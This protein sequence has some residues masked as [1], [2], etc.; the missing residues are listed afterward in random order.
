[1]KGIENTTRAMA[2][3]LRKYDFIEGFVYVDKQNLK[4]F[5]LSNLVEPGERNF[6]HHPVQALFTFRDSVILYICRCDFADYQQ[7]FQNMPP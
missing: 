1:V 5:K 4:T 3:D 2:I 6:D 7:H